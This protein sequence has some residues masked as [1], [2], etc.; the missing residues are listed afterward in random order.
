VYPL[1][2]A[3][4][5]FDAFT[6]LPVPMPAV[7]CPVP[8]ASA[9]ASDA[10]GCVASVGAPALGAPSIACPTTPDGKGT[11]PTE[12]LPP[13]VVTGAT[14][15]LM[16]T[17]DTEPLL[18]PAWLFTIDGA[19]DTLPMIAVQPSYLGDPSAGS[20]SASSSPGSSGGGSVTDPGGSASAIPPGE[21]VP[22]TAVA[23]VAPTGSVTVTAAA[24]GADGRTLTLTGWGGVC[25][26][27][28]ADAKETAT[29]VYVVITATP[30]VGKDTACIEIAKE[31]SADV[32]LAAPL[33]SRTVIDGAS[34]T[35]VK[36]G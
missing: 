18:V 24:L 9:S 10:I 36:V 19:S 35:P 30:T 29:E 5:A 1:V 4:Q 28:A 23:P 34:G 27:Y 22:T 8:S 6:A 12:T 20:G 14:L 7:D 2:T 26:S 33:G 13:T 15:G 11:C 16:L 3:Q 25:A 21:P 17:W 31:I 32:T